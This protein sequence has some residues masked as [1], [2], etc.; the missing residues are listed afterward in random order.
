MSWNKKGVTTH[1][2]H[3]GAGVWSRSDIN[4]V[5]IWSTYSLPHKDNIWLKYLLIYCHK[6][7]LRQRRWKKRKEQK[8][9]GRGK[10][11]ETKSGGRTEGERQRRRDRK[12]EFHVFWRME[13]IDFLIAIRCWEHCWHSLACKVHHSWAYSISPKHSFPLK[14]WI[15]G[16]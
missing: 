1:R 14:T 11:K 2:R 10:E 16:W 13:T 8:V 4:I 7:N 3:L 9:M 5:C 6:W 15:L 12:L